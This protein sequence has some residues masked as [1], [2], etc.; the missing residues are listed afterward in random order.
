MA[1]QRKKAPE[2]DWQHKY[3]EL[4]HYFG[5]AVAQYPLGLIEGTIEVH[6]PDAVVFTHYGAAVLRGRARSRERAV[7]RAWDIATSAERVLVGQ[8]SYKFLDKQWQKC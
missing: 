6:W 2:R 7:A 8:T 1:E 3:H 5:N 4:S